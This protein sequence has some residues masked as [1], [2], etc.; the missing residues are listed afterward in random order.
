M[1]VSI[2]IIAG[3]LIAGAFLIWRPQ[4]T[5]GPKTPVMPDTVEQ[6][7]TKDIA[8]TELPSRD[9]IVTTEQNNDVRYVNY[10]N[11]NFDKSR[12]KVRV[13]FFYASWCPT[14]RPAG[15][16]LTNNKSK[17]PEDV[18]VFRVNY[19]DP[20]TDQDEK[21]L[22]KKYNI[23]YQHTYVQIDALGKQVAKWN[24]GALN[25]LLANIK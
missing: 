13:L 2:V 17:I 3:I 21:D 19:N 10:S 24:G 8:N 5:P 18:V 6:P 20:D 7:I 22:A 9:E 14:C 11:T 23:T 1:P 25:E 4:T 12:D 16:D 15:T